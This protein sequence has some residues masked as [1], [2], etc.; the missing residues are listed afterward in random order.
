[1]STPNHTAIFTSLSKELNAM[2]HSG[3][4][5]F[6]RDLYFLSKTLPLP[7][8]AVKGAFNMSGTFY[9]SKHWLC[10]SNYVFQHC[11]HELHKTIDLSLY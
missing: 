10:P 6:S 9:Q 11:F 1:M 5:Q 4:A 2:I 8:R 3:K 7:T